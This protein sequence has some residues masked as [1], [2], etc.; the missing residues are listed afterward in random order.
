LY[1]LIT[2]VIICIEDG[3]SMNGNWSLVSCNHPP[4][5][6]IDVTITS[7]YASVYSGHLER[8]HHKYSCIIDCKML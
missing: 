8:K 2:D 3:Y 7:I 1:L 4:Y 6:I 5:V